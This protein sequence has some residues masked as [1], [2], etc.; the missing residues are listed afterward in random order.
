MPNK[1]RRRALFLAALGL[2]VSGLLFLPAAFGE[3]AQSAFGAPLAVMLK[4]PSLTAG[5]VRREWATLVGWFGL[6]DENRRLKNELTLLKLDH[7]QLQERVALLQRGKP[8]LRFGGRNL[9]QLIP[10]SLLGR[11]PSTWFN[12][13]TLDRGSA[14][15]VPNGAGVIGAEGVVG[16]VAAVGPLSCKVVFLIDPSCRIA[17]RDTRSR[18]AATLVGSG[19]NSCHLLYLSGQDDIRPGDL[20]ETAAEG[21][22][23]APGI[24][25]G[26]VVRVEKRDNGLNLFAEVKP[27]VKLSLLEDFYILGSRE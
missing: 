20:V 25:V 22:I 23:F 14:D 1:P 16:K 11:D 4:V 19:R 21:T 24:P 15:S 13:V 12:Y 5:K 27:S 6:G 2:G 8:E 10:A 3:R 26:E 9:R 17:V 18:I 7:Q